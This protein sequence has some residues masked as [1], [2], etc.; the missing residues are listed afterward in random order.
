MIFVAN[1]NLNKTS[2]NQIEHYQ[3]ARYSFNN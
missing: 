2:I 1:E 3:L